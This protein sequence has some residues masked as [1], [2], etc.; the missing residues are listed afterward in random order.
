MC[1]VIVV[2]ISNTF[3]DKVLQFMNCLHDSPVKMMG[4]GWG[5]G[6]HTWGWGQHV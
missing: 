4:T 6:W 1:M 5:S 2:L 3:D